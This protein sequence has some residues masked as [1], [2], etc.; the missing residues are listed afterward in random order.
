[1]ARILQPHYF[2]DC[3]RLEAGPKSKSSHGWKSF[4]YAKELIKT[5]MRY[6]I[7]DGTI[8]NIWT[9]HWIP[10]HPPRPARALNNFY[11]TSR[12]SELLL[13]DKRDWDEAKLRELI[14]AENV[15]R[16]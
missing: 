13:P 4:I 11:S 12:I 1:M 6:V 3:C 2:P 14:V 7:G 10:D 8:I 5:G 16:I 9:D 15:E